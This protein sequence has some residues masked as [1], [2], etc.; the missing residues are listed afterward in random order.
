MKP[1]YANSL[2]FEDYF[3]TEENC[4]AALK[5]LRW[6]KGFICPNCG[7]DDGYELT[8][9]NL[10]QCASCRKQT[11]VT[12]GTIFE[13]THMPLRIWFRIIY[14]MAQDKGGASSS[15]L[16]AQLGIP[17]K[18]VWHMM[19]KIRIA[20]GNRNKNIPLGGNIELDEAFF[21]GEARKYQPVSRTETQVLVMCES[22][23]ERAGEVVMKVIDEASRNDIREVV[24]HY[25]GDP[26]HNPDD[27][28]Q[29]FTADGWHAHWVLWSMQHKTDIKPLP[30]KKGVEKLPWVHTMISL[31]RR[32]LVGTYHGVSPQKLQ[33]YLDELC[34][35]INRRFRESTI[36]ESLLRACVFSL[37]TTCAELRL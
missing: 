26:E 36:C 29:H 2:V 4:V 5:E 8:R 34:F 7:H 32:F 13:R 37:P 27:L 33:L 30:G 23:G 15:R 17:Q 12:A 25:I 1:N 9:G 16:A 3:R 11:S 35:R 21:N 19:H 10:I 28:P 6:P 20:M 31:A 22:E 24:Q 18:T 14:A